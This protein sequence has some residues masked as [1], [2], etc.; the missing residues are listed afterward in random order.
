MP[1]KTGIR[2][3]HGADFSAIL[4]I[5]QPESGPQS[6]ACGNLP[7]GV[8]YTNVAC[9]AAPNDVV[10]DDEGR[11]ITVAIDAKP[12]LQFKAKSSAWRRGWKWKGDVRVAPAS[13]D[14]LWK[15]DAAA[16]AAWR[17]AWMDRVSVAQQQEYTEEENAVIARGLALL[18]GF[19]AASGKMREDRSSSSRVLKKTLSSLHVLGERER[20]KLDRATGRLLGEVQLVVRG[21][22]FDVVAFLM[23]LGGQ[24]MQRIINA[25]TTNAV[26]AELLETV[27]DHCAI[28]FNEHRTNAVL[29]NR[30]FLN[31]VVWKQLST[32]P[33]NYIVSGVPLDA[34]RR[35]SRKDE[36]HAIRGL[37]CRTFL[38]TELSDKRALLRYHGTQTPLPDDPTRLLPGGRYEGGQPRPK[39]G[40]STHGP[41]PSAAMISS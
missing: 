12:F 16:D 21:E 15:A 4:E 32:I 40:G 24:R 9:D 17:A 29:R 5:N 6:A 13:D 1:T 19:E 20:T 7:P 34:H 27:N 8:A 37:V 10:P 30:T 25:G 23:H 2:G 35:I 26:R 33:A 14:G 31:R 41:G 39:T 38:V 11:E 18:E 36:K 3:S 22:A 28:I